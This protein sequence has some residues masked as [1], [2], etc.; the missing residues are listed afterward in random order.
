MSFSE[1]KEF[2]RVPGV[3]SRK[4][5]TE[6]AQQSLCSVAEE[7]RPEN[8]FPVVLNQPVLINFSDSVAVR[9]WYESHHQTY[10]LVGQRRNLS[11]RLKARIFGTE[12]QSEKHIATFR[13]HIR[14]VG[15][16]R[17]V[18]LMVGAGTMGIGTDQLYADETILQ[19]AFD[20]YPSALTQFVADAH[21]IPLGNESVDAVCIQAVIEHV[22]EPEKVISE[23][24]RVLKPE[25]IVYAETPFMQQVHEGAYDFTRFTELGHRWLFRDFECVESGSLGGVGLSLYWAAKYFLRGLTRS[26]KVGNF[27]SL[28]FLVFALFDRFVPEAY[29]VDGA[30]GVYFIGRKSDHSVN[31]D[32]VISL[33]KGAQK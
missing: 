16:T 25:G 32:E 20:V 19:I 10:S 1:L 22:L 3:P 9:D 2:L 7:G 13:T 29:N 30:N 31:L 5:I 11:R 8:A 28:P 4:V 17:P 12:A 23:I 6:T 24:R 27:L 15:T 33:Y 14:G 18:L 26:H 21:S